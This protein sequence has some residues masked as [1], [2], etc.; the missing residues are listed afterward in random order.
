[1]PII[2]SDTEQ[3]H[4]EEM[5]DII[6]SPPA[7][8]L[9]WG[10][11]LFFALLVLIVSLSAFIRYPDTVKAQL[12]INSY[13]SPKLVVTK[14]PG[15]LV[16]ILIHEK[17]KVYKDQELA[18]LEST[19]KHEDVLQLYKDLKKIQH[20]FFD[21]K[22]GSSQSFNTPVRLQLGELQ[23]SYQSFYQAYLVYKPSVVDGFYLK[24]RTFLQSDLTTIL[25]QKEQLLA[26]QTLQEKDYDL[27]RQEYVVHQKLL[28][29]KVEAPMELKRE[30]G[31]LLA[32]EFPLQQTKAS[33][34]QNAAAYSVKEREILELNNQ[35]KEEKLKFI[36]ALNTLISGIE[37]WKSKY[38]LSA[39]QSGTLSFSGIIQENQLLIANQEVFYISPANSAFFGVMGIQQYNMGKVKEEQKVLIK[40]RS[41]PYEEYGVI[42]GKL[43]NISEV[44]FRDSIF[45][46]RVVFEGDYLPKSKKPIK[47]KMECWQMPK[48]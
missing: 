23:S 27:V 7:W 47:L 35:I 14:G 3:Q 39:P 31:K 10:I 24:K 43:E 41:Y 30:E 33:L 45:I 8:L 44:P 26:Q 13:N 21:N 11:T 17:Q 37:D 6:T 46:S 48:L 1:M 36:Q 34:I 16:E 4:T 22:P 42:W 9:R 38:V 29:E 18:Y 5:H 2:Y 25:K 20:Q 12:E 28:A 19:A 15:M 32:K 40:L